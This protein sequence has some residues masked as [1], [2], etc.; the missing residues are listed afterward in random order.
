M[1]I[2]E[3]EEQPVE[4]DDD[5][6]DICHTVCCLCYDEGREPLITVCGD[7]QLRSGCVADDTP[8]QDCVVCEDGIANH[9]PC[10][11]CGVPM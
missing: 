2:T 7:L 6:P 8:V 5:G 3:V 10:P 1:I 9:A 11:M 4:L